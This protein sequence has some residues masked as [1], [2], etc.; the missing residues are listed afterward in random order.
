MSLTI[1]IYHLEAYD[2]RGPDVALQSSREIN[3]RA[4]KLMEARAA[5]NRKLFDKYGNPNKMVFLDRSETPGEQFSG[6]IP[7][8]IPKRLHD[9]TNGYIEKHFYQ[10]KKPAK[11]MLR[12]H[13]AQSAFN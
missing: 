7:I 12:S 13:K 2:R 3:P 8:D 5:G 1:S 4:Y 9:D 10:T 6:T 11:S